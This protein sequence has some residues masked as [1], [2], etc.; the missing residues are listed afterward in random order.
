MGPSFDVGAHLCYAILTAK[1]QVIHRTTVVPLTVEEKN[2]DDIKQMKAEFTE[3]LKN[4]LGNKAEGTGMQEDNEVIDNTKFTVPVETINDETTPTFELY[5]DND[6][7]QFENS[8]H[9]EE[10]NQVEFDKY[11]SAQVR[12][13]YIC[14]NVKFLFKVRKYQ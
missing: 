7:K 1:G 2:G 6:E 12:I 11:V 5:E 9:K 4:R 8:Q 14:I 13:R 10:D 3:E